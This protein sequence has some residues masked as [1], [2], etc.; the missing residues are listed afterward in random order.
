MPIGVVGGSIKLTPQSQ[1]NYQISQIKSAKEL[2]GVIVA[3]GLAQNLAALRA[4]PPP[5]SKRGT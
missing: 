4:W 5:V 2:A 3:G 1:V